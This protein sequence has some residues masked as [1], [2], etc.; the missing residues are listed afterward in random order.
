MTIDHD[1]CWQALVEEGFTP[2]VVTHLESCDSC[3]RLATGLSRA[4][5]ALALQPPA[6]PSV[7]ADRVLE[8]VA[9][10]R[11]VEAGAAQDDRVRL[12]RPRST[13]TPPPTRS[14]LRRAAAR[15]RWIWTAVAV[16]VALTTVIVMPGDNPAVAQVVFTSD[17]GRDDLAGARAGSDGSLKGRQLVVAATWSDDEE[18]NFVDMVL[19]RFHR[20][21][22]A[23][24]SFAS[25][26]RDI[27]QT[28]SDRV[29]GNCP[30]DVAFLPQP[31]L[32]RDFVHR[33]GGSALEPLD[34][35]VGDLVSANYDPAWRELATVDD[36]LYGVWFK[37]ANKS[38]VWYNAPTFVDADVTPPK[39]WEEWKLVSATLRERTD[40]APIAVAGADGWT[41]TDWFENVYLRTAGP[42]MYDRLAKGQDIRWTDPTVKSALRTMG[43]LLGTE[44]WLAG[45]IA[46]ALKT[47]YEDSVNL[48]FG[49]HARA[50]MVYEGDF[51]ATEIKKAGAE[52]G[53]T[54]RSFDF[55][56][57]DPSLPD[58]PVAGGDVAVLLTNNEAGKEFLRF[59]ASGEAAIP[60]VQAGGFLSPN[61]A[62][63][64]S[65]YRSE[66]MAEAALPL[67]NG[68]FRF[69][70]SDLQP[71]C[72]GA[73]GT[74][75]MRR[76]LQ[77]H[78]ANPADV[79]HTAAQLE[80]ASKC[81]S[82]ER[83]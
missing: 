10:A 59:L 31:G 24:V 34:G 12:R 65:V 42:E 68:D 47:K 56:V 1:A 45:G 57:I 9:R 54:A 43:E 39:T 22:G 41:L 64:N 23:K 70:L 69:D 16:A 55:P 38:L 72:F 83:G 3:A 62:V 53:R 36:H 63:G 4:R 49:R 46:G 33:P 27:A 60:L 35:V 67:V 51:A 28:L 6:A 17:C 8:R 18:A 74:E 26:S 73:K 25:Q 7:L 80:R 19:E 44:E 61:K 11:S 2:T 40:V 78:L 82:T 58:I 77:D 21:T 20:Q 76:I 5:E 30:P 66:A 48:V 52:L 81:G 71:S 32:L 13:G 50:A 75:G 37:A 29:D 14:S 15:S 79:D